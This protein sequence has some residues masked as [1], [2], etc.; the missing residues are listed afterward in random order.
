MKVFKSPWKRRPYRRLL[1]LLPIPLIIC[2]TI[3]LLLL[4]WNHLKSAELAELNNGRTGEIQAF[5]AQLKE[6][7]QVIGGAQDE[8]TNAESYFQ[9][10]Q[11]RYQEAD[12]EINENFYIPFDVERAT[13]IAEQAGGLKKNL[14]LLLLDHQLSPQDKQDA[15]LSYTLNVYLPVSDFLH[16]WPEHRPSDQG[17]PGGEEEK[18]NVRLEMLSQLVPLVPEN[19]ATQEFTARLFPFGLAVKNFDG[20]NYQLLMDEY[21]QILRSAM[22][23]AMVPSV[24][25]YMK[26]AKL[27]TIHHM[28]ELV[29]DQR[30]M[31]GHGGPFAS[32]AS[33]QGPFDVGLPAQ[34]YSEE[35]SSSERF[36]RIDSLLIQNGIYLNDDP[37]IG[38]SMKKY[39]LDTDTPS[40]EIGNGFL[41]QLPFQRFFAAK[42]ALQGSGKFA[43]DDLTEYDLVVSLVT[44]THGIE[45]QKF[46]HQKQTPRLARHYRNPQNKIDFSAVEK[47]ITEIITPFQLPIT[48]QMSAEDQQAT[49]HLNERFFGVNQYLAARTLNAHQLT[50]MQVIPASV[51]AQLEKNQINLNIFPLKN[52]TDAWMQWILH[53]MALA[54]FAPE[55][56]ETLRFNMPTK[57]CSNSNNSLNPCKSGQVNFEIAFEKTQ[58][59]LREF[60]PATQ[61][62]V[63]NYFKTYSTFNDNWGFLRALWELMAIY[64]MIPPYFMNEWE[65]LKGQMYL[66]NYW[67]A[68][69]LSFLMEM[70][71]LQNTN[72]AFRQHLSKLAQYFGLHRPLHPFHSNRILSH[73]QQQT[74]WH[75]IIAQQNVNSANLFNTESTYY[76]PATYYDFLHNLDKSVIFREEEVKTFLQGVDP[77]GPELV[78][79]QEELATIR[80][81]RDH[82]SFQ[83]YYDLLQAKGNLPLQEKIVQKILQ[84]AEFQHLNQY[85]I[86]KSFY[87]NLQAIK[88]PIYRY[89]ITTAAQKKNMELLLAIDQLCQYDIADREE[90]KDL[91]QATSQQQQVMKEM[92]KIKTPKVIEERNSYLNQL[93]LYATY[94]GI[95]SGISY[96]LAIGLTAFSKLPLVAISLGTTALG[97]QVAT[98][99]LTYYDVLA[100]QERAGIIEDFVE[101]GYATPNAPKEIYRSM[102]AWPLAELAFIAPMISFPARLITIAPAYLS[103]KSQGLWKQM[104]KIERQRFLQN[105]LENAETKWGQYNMGELSL[106]KTWQETWQLVQQGPNNVKNFFIRAFATIPKEMLDP[107][108]VKNTAAEINRDFAQS[109]S[110]FFWH[111]PQRFIAFLESFTKNRLFGTSGTPSKI[112]LAQNRIQKPARWAFTKW[113]KDNAEKFL[114]HQETLYRLLDEVKALPATPNALANFL[115]TNGEELSAFLEDALFRKREIFYY[116]F[117]LGAPA[118]RGRGLMLSKLA[119]LAVLQRLASSRNHLLYQSYR[120]TA[121][122]MLKLP[123]GVRVHKTSDLISAYQ[124]A[125]ADLQQLLDF[126]KDLSLTSKDLEKL[127]HQMQENVR[128]YLATQPQLA[129]ILPADARPLVEVLFAPQNMQ[130]ETLAKLIWEQIPTEKIINLETNGNTIRKVAE[131]L[132]AQF[133]KEDSSLNKLLALEAA[134]KIRLLQTAP[135]IVNLF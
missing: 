22:I 48:G 66:K 41:R 7:S 76:S 64:K 69:R 79:L 129:Q 10:I 124:S 68:A 130:E 127:W 88:L 47:T 26:A 53:R 38:E 18:I 99:G 25:N 39:Y 30:S 120:Q 119:E 32:P 4:P 6:F 118:K 73:D 58:N 36:A 133:V 43:I 46:T 82:G 5:I 111:N 114:Q 94:T 11:R 20:N 131:E 90:F 96:L 23:S 74:L 16:L 35:L 55:N 80:A 62:Y 12:N 9:E 92:L 105:S 116:L 67:A 1:M 123:E 54:F 98:F 104:S 121:S 108:I 14:H 77:K 95:T 52:A 3:F 112:V 135:P 83:Y 21:R 19:L 75:E 65:Y 117:A 128:Q 61:D 71:Q 100:S 89:L 51:I 17:G 122:Q 113:R 81:D 49:A 15:L 115:E 91:Y 24:F 109:V 28:L 44:K 85:Q 63:P 84:Q 102:Y 72:I 42:K 125:L 31:A 87:E 86:R 134:I 103:V 56:E 37:L 60:L 34:L 107:A 40:L 106:S 13:K 93:D 8:S 97:T 70:D 132:A 101:L 45:L 59:F 110:L 27:S 29:R 126:K 33:C 50:W 78:K 57:N 2:I